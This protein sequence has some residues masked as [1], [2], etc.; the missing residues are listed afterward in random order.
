[1]FTCTS[2]VISACTEGAPPLYGTCTSRTPVRCMNSS[3]DMWV[4]V[5]APL[6]P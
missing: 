4:P 3:I 1:M 6:V 2:F 5:A